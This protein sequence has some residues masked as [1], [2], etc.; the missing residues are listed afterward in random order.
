MKKAFFQPS[1]DSVLHALTALCVSIGCVYPMALA[2]GLV[3]SRTYCVTCCAAAVLFL[4]IFEWMP[5]LRLVFGTIALLAASLLIVRHMDQMRAFGTAFMLMLGGHPVALA[6][7]S[8]LV[9][10]LLSLLYAGVG[11]LFARSEGAFLPLALVSAVMLFIVSHL[12]MQAM[13]STLIP[14]SLAMLLSWRKPD[15]SLTRIL[16]CAAMVLLLCLPLLRFI[17]RT[18]PEMSDFAERVRQT[19]DDYFF[20]TEP[21]TT[22]SLNSTGWQPL[23]VDRLGGPV[24]PLPDPVMQVRVSRR[25]LLRGTIKNEYTGFAWQDTTS[26]RRYQFYDPRFYG[27]RRNLFDLNRPDRKTLAQLS[28]EETVDV[29]LLADAAST[30][31]LTQR[32]SA[33][34]GKD[35]VPYYSPASE[36]FATRSLDKGDSYSF[37]GVLFTASDPGVREAVIASYDDDDPYYATVQG[38]YTQLP[39]MVEENVYALARSLTANETNDFDRAMAICRYL[40]SAY[41]YT[42]NQNEPPST[43]DFV[44]WFLLTERQGYCTSFASA[45]AVMA[46]AVNLPSRYVEGYVA[47]PDD[48]GIAH[49]T[50]LNAHA[51]AEVYFPGFG[52]L[53]F[54]PTP[55]IRDNAGED[56]SNSS[57]PMSTPSPTPTLVPSP[58][59]EQADFTVTPTPSITPAPTLMPTATPK[60]APEHTS[61]NRDLPLLTLL[62]L[63]MLILLALLIMLRF[64]WTSPE[65]LA[66]RQHSAADALLVWYRAIEDALSCM[67]IHS[68]PG[69][70]PATFMQRAQKQLNHIVPL[71]QLASAL[72]I[73]SYSDHQ[74]KTAQVEHAEKLY[75]ALLKVASHRQRVKIVLRRFFRGIRQT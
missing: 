41:P 28:D 6:A 63:F 52:W 27:L 60:D 31:Y 66:A 29:F 25:A 70:A 72:C 21:R 16:I 24:S 12:D 58:T 39:D 3:A 47:E 73:A 8:R 30:I 57:S 14:L 75:H 13:L 56:I 65:N 2:L 53:P 64:R 19:V 40:Q 61:P 32:F 1:T 44:S 62:A 48:D 46:R 36:V 42:L 15:V 45:L 26:G 38:T 55:G 11:V 22:F 49:V 68:A 50:Q 67:G 54:D 23:G 37:S 74:L 9:I 17:G 33:L 59:P 7:Y 51:W 43:R 10:L 34:S 71:G 69:E 5:R 20:F 4:L 18:I 35:I